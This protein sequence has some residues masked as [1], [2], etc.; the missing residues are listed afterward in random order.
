MGGKGERYKFPVISHRNVMYS[1]GNIV[2]KIV[3]ILYGD[4]LLLALYGSDRFVRY[5]NAELPCCT[6]EAN[7]VLYVN[8]N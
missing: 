6:P 5:I 2:N 7:I 8:Y 1:I 4:R 3:I